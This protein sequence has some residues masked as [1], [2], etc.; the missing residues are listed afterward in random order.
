MGVVLFGD[1]VAMTFRN[2]QENGKFSSLVVSQQQYTRTFHNVTS[3]S[4]CD[5]E[6]SLP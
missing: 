2:L 4:L 3:I 5:I 6:S 1:N